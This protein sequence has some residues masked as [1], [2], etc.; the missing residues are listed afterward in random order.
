MGMCVRVCVRG[1]G[2]GGGGRRLR[3]RR[4]RK[5]QGPKRNARRAH[6]RGN[7]IART[8][9]RGD[10]QYRFEHACVYVCVGK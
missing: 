6:V 4:A 7:N 1:G 9:V 3:H 2:G 10:V 8:P 5:G